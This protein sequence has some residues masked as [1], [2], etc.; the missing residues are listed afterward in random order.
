M[1]TGMLN[2]HQLAAIRGRLGLS[3]EQMARLLGVS[4][5][6]VNRWEGGHSS[7]TGPTRDIYLAVDAA[8]RTGHAP[9]VI[10]QAANGERGRFLYVLFRMAYAETRRSG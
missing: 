4:F 9:R 3:Q 1:L 6:S 8:L 10:L 5:A 2:P 7:P